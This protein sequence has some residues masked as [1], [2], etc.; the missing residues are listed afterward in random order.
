MS[1]KYV[2]VLLSLSIFAILYKYG[3]VSKM[4]VID[5]TKLWV[6]CTHTRSPSPS[7]Q[8]HTTSLL[9]SCYPLFPDAWLSLSCDFPKRLL[10]TLSFPFFP[11]VGSLCTTNFGL[12]SC[13]LDL[14][15]MCT[16]QFPTPQMS[17]F[18]G[19]CMPSL[20]SS[21]FMTRRSRRMRSLESSFFLI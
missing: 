16:G 8:T 13:Y 9:S 20:V 5:W 1:L 3:Q 4:I 15:C 12:G 6:Q 2:A 11:R 19:L 17:Y 18:G 21:S 14:S 7:T 10:F